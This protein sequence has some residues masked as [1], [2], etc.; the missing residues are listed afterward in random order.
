MKKF[1]GLLVGV[2][3]CIDVQAA[4]ICQ[5]Q[6]S[7]AGIRVCVQNPG[8][9]CLSLPRITSINAVTGNIPCGGG[10]TCRVRFS[11]IAISSCSATEVPNCNN[12]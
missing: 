10:R 4:C 11:N 12:F 2:L 3:L 1:L 8:V 7:P 5:L 6:S 9:Q